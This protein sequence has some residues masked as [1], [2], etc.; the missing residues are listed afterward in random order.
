MLANDF[1]SGRSSN[2]TAKSASRLSNAVK[3]VG[4][5]QTSALTFGLAQRVEFSLRAELDRWHT[6]GQ[7]VGPSATGLQ[8]TSAARQYRRSRYLGSHFGE[9]AS[10]RLCASGGVVVAQR[11]S[12]KP[13]ATLLYCRRFDRSLVTGRRTLLP[14][15]STRLRPPSGCTD[16]NQGRVAIATDLSAAMD[17]DAGEAAV[18]RCSSV[19]VKDEGLCQTLV[20]LPIRRMRDRLR[21]ILLETPV[22]KT[23]LAICE[24]K[25]CAEPKP[26]RRAMPT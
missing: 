9:T 7:V 22:P 10:G 11:G 4:L 6:P 21:P 19:P 24:G 2:R 3:F 13:Q 14:G 23:G 16:A 25:G 12:A 20:H 17:P 26:R 18:R 1:D 15:V 5:S 8:P